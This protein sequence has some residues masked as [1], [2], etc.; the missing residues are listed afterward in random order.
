MKKKKTNV[1]SQI[2]KYMGYTKPALAM[3]VL[4]GN[5]RIAV[6]LLFL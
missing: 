3:Y 5:C 6:I 1:A 4:H 2:L